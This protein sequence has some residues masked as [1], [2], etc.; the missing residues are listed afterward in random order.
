MRRSSSYPSFPSSFSL[1]LFVVLLGL[2]SLAG[3][4]AAQSGCTA[5]VTTG[6]NLTLCPT[7][8]SLLTPPPQTNASVVLTYSS[9]GALNVDDGCSFRLNSTFPIHL[10]GSLYDEMNV[11]SNG[12]ISFGPAP[13][14]F[15]SLPLPVYYS[16]DPVL[17]IIAPFLANLYINYSMGN[18]TISFEGSAPS[19]SIVVRYSQIAYYVTRS[20]LPSNSIS[21]DVIL[22]EDPSAGFDV[23]YYNVSDIATSSITVSIGAQANDNGQS[24]AIL[25]ANGTTFSSAILTATA[26]F[27]PARAL[28]GNTLHFAFTGQDVSSYTCSGLG[29][30]FSSYANSSDLVW[31]NGTAVYYY[32]PCG[33]VSASVCTSTITAERAQ[34]CIFY[35]ATNKTL[36]I[37]NYQPQTA[38]YSYLPNGVQVVYQNGPY[39]STYFAEA[40]SVYQ[41]VC[42]ATATTPLLSNVTWSAGFVHTLTI[43]SAIA[44]GQGNRA[45]VS[46]TPLYPTSTL[47]SCL[48]NAGSNYTVT[49]CPRNS[50]SV[51]YTP[52]PMTNPT[53]ILQTATSAATTVLQ[54]AIPLG[55]TFFVYDTAY[56]NVTIGT[57]GALSFGAIPYT[58][59]YGAIST[60]GQ[61]SGE[62]AYPVL[63]PFGGNYNLATGIP[64]AGFPSNS[65]ISY[66]TEGVAPNRQFIARFSNLVFSTYSQYLYNFQGVSF[67]VVLSEGEPGGIQFRYYSVPS[68][69]GAL[70]VQFVRYVTIG[71][72]GNADLVNQWTALSAYNYVSL[73][74]PLAANLQGATA[75]FSYTGITGSAACGAAGANFT[76]L[77]SVDLVYSDVVGANTYYVRPCG[78]VNASICSS[79]VY[80]SHAQVCQ[81]PFN[82]ASGYLIS[83]YNPSG[84]YWQPSPVA[85][86]VRERTLDGQYC[87]SPVFA[88]RIVNL[89]YIC[90]P[91]A[92]TANISSVTESP[93]CT[94]NIAIQTAAACSA[95]WSCYAYND[96]SVYSAQICGTSAAYLTQTNPRSIL[97]G[98]DDGTSRQQL[99][100]PFH[101]YGVPWDRV[102]VN[103]NGALQFGGSSAG[104]VF[105]TLPIPASSWDAT[106]AFLPFGRDLSVQNGGSITVSNETMPDGRRAFVVRFNNVDYAGHTTA[107]S[108]EAVSFDVILYEGLAGQIDV[109][110]YRVDV[111]PV[112]NVLVGFQSNDEESFVVLVL[113]QP[114]SSTVQSQL[115]GWTFSWNYTGVDQSN[116][117]ACGGLGYDLSS[118]TTF[119]DLSYT[120]GSSV[121][122]YRPC[123][124]VSAAA[125][126]ATDATYRSSLCLASSALPTATTTSLMVYNPSL[127]IYSYL[128]NG[129]QLVVQDGQFCSAV[130]EARVTIVQFVCNNATQTP[131]ITYAGEGPTCVTTLIVATPAACSGGY[132]SNPPVNTYTPSTLTACT[133]I[134]GVGYSAQWCPR[135]S[136]DIYASPQ[137]LTNRTVWPALRADDA[138]LGIALPFTFYFYDTPF[139]SLFVDTNGLITFGPGGGTTAANPSPFPSLNLATADAYPV[140][141]P[142]FTNL[143]NLPYGG[144]SSSPL[145]AY[146]GSIVTSNEGVAPNRQFILRW[147][148]VSYYNLRTDY[149]PRGVT[150]DVVLSEGEP[151]GIAIRYYQVDANPGQS[152]AIGLHGL[153]GASYTSATNAL[154]LSVA[155][156]AQLTSSTLT[157]TYT[158]VTDASLCGGIAAFN[159]SG[160]G[161]LKYSGG[162]YTY[163]IHPCGPTVSS[164]CASNLN[165]R[166]AT[167][168]QE[169][170]GAGTVIAV[171]TPAAAV[172]TYPNNATA[173]QIIQ[174]G[175][176]CATAGA[177]RRSTIDYVCNAA[178]SSFISSVNETSPCQFYAVVQTP[179]VCSSCGGA[180]SGQ[181]YTGQQCYTQ[182]TTLQTM[183]VQTN[184]QPLLTT[185]ALIDDGLQR[186]QLPLAVSVYGSP[187]DQVTVCVNGFLFFGPGAYYGAT[188]G[189]F[190]LSASYDES[191]PFIAPYWVDLYNQNTLGT[192]NITWSVEGTAPSRL[193][194]I[195]WS[196]VAYYTGHGVASTERFVN[197]DVRVPESSAQP[198]QI[199]YYRMDLPGTTTGVTI[200]I[201]SDDT[202]SQTVMYQS[203]AAT[204]LS[205]LLQNQ[206]IT[207]AFTGNDTSGQCGS[208]GYNFASLLNTTLSLSNFTG[209]STANSTATY[210]LAPCGVVNAT[211]CSSS[212]STE[213]S[214]VCGV[215]VTGSSTRIQNQ[216][217][218]SRTAIK[219]VYETNGLQAIL[220]TGT[221]CSAGA[222]PNLP[223]Y[224][225]PSLTYIDFLCDPATP[226]AALVG[227]TQAGCTTSFAVNTSLACGGGLRSTTVNRPPSPS[228]LAGCMNRTGSSYNAQV[229]PRLPSDPYYLPQNMTSPTYILQGN[230]D[231]PTSVILPFPVYLYEVPYTNVTISPNGALFFGGSYTATVTTGS[232]PGL[233]LT[234][235]DYFPVVA[236]F[237][238]NLIN[239]GV[240]PQVLYP[241]SI[242]WSIEG[243]APNRTFLLRFSAVSYYY[244][245]FFPNVAASFDVLLSEGDASAITF[246]YYRIDSSSAAQQV[247]SIGIHGD[248]SQGA[249]SSSYTVVANSQQLSVQFV[250]DLQGS[251][252]TLTYNGTLASQACTYN[253]YNLSAVSG[254]DLVYNSTATQYVYYYRPCGIV[255]APICHL[256]PTMAE[257]T[258]CQANYDNADIFSLAVHNPSALRYATLYNQSQV[259][260]VVEYL[261]DGQYCNGG[262]LQPRAMV[263]QYICDPT[264]TTP[265]F[266]NL[267]EAPQCTYTGQIRTSVVC[268]LPMSSTAARVSSSAGSSS[269]LS[270]SVLSSSALSSSVASSSVAS[271][272]TFSSSALSS[273]AV[274]SSVVASS[275]VTSAAAPTSA[276]ATSAPATSAQL[277][278]AAAAT[279][280]PVVARSSSTTSAPATSAPLTT[281][282]PLATST[283]NPATS[284]PAPAPTSR[285]VTSAAGA[286]AATVTSAAAPPTSPLPA[287]AA[288]S[289]SSTGAAVAPGGGSSSSGLSGGAIAGIVIGAVAGAGLLLC[290]I[291]L[292][293]FGRSRAAKK[294]A[295][296]AA[297]VK[298]DS[299]SSAEPSE[300]AGGERKQ[301]HA[302]KSMGSNSELSMHGTDK[303]D[304]EGG[305]ELA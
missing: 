232:F 102:Y 48:A 273:S 44:C 9:T 105:N 111:E 204:T 87:P 3:F 120:N 191:L 229:C 290:L 186:V 285:L 189:T 54:T 214:A 211:V 254:S 42:N 159:L 107:G 160:V 282:T 173:R 303:D 26:G 250:S 23:R 47:T 20:T 262:T 241:G 202:I 65:S 136:T 123:G 183:P 268:P 249:S 293:A 16:N 286:T 71:M 194:I 233:G 17:P 154:P 81:V 83:V 37:S 284:A 240:D 72:H 304:D 147:S 77:N 89:D 195:R 2:L 139:S 13:T 217:I 108:E 142:F 215:F 32:H 297:P 197:M 50:T 203:V 207:Y 243:V 302:L 172:W 181:F 64:L 67:D 201:Q 14:I 38:Q 119:G 176:Y 252:V 93:Q 148:T 128:P 182:Q 162:G 295:A 166:T 121:Y 151:G 140:I 178:G 122:Y 94:Y 276:A 224:S 272:S 80:T 76:A 143:F 208:L 110:Y 206:T 130:G 99:A 134:S 86:G 141:A 177:Q 260:G 236:P 261:Q 188:T 133:S 263:M 298:G 28:A 138:A 127:H 270:S 70:G 266:F 118:L 275:S 281:S 234:A 27:G 144:V 152:V 52:V 231:N 75:T 39:V 299:D 155:L 255:S 169:V 15:T 45:A 11:C 19:R 198:L 100:F 25:A 33:V 248:D 161:D 4:A 125:C 287:L 124:V 300:K 12:Y 116:T 296:A 184:P 167:F 115:Q 230:D 104:G 278:S 51:G 59:T 53:F 218:W 190:P 280:T 56:T 29:Y 305:I 126:Q 146:N 227:W 36:L 96:G 180:V 226:T 95:S 7:A 264:A 88:P 22:Y 288:S 185:S 129:L 283:P 57:N 145:T 90:N 213:R 237:F 158:G 289:S 221:Y 267:T 228:T 85:P 137:A 135:P 265:V 212:S 92:L 18:I 216:A 40:I 31:N 131:A 24:Y 98:V 34:A 200:G 66:S 235:G 257:T 301:L 244:T 5:Q 132:R 238:T 246:R 168:C 68:F 187:W 219:W 109:R 294:D 114:V 192:S 74:Q 103:S 91:L 165:L 62:D 174:D 49:L 113:P 220:N 82:A 170:A 251:T 1:F 35:P 171:D 101:F 247:V 205:T 196:Q 106:P 112:G 46:V 10:Y 149:A 164:A 269:A 210:Y 55:F 253:G 63:L 150:F 163:T 209:N 73:S 258:L 8:A 225:G 242:S 84:I 21:F 259:A 97:A 279:S 239:G 157:F 78:T 245:V 277:T 79:S 117:S 43:Q 153:D 30:D 61:T 274:S 41:F 199:I 223:A 69:T 156:A 222:L 256:Y 175:Q 292:V 179:M 60:S 193:L 271:S 58:S 6:Y 291:L